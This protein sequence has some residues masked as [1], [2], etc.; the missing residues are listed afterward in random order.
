MHVRVPQ[1]FARAVVARE[2]EAGA[3]FVEGLPGVV[4]GLARRW[5]LRQD[6][7]VLHGQVA[8]VVLVV[9]DDRT[10]A[11]LKVSWRDDETRPE[12]TPLRRWAGVGAVRLLDEDAEAG[13]LLLERLEPQRTLEEVPLDAALAVAAA[14]L[15]ELHVGPVPGVP[16]PRDKAAA[17]AARV[18][19]WAADAGGD[20]RSGRSTRRRRVGLVAR[21]VEQLRSA[22]ATPS[23]DVLLHD[24]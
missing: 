12:A 10:P 4:S 7:P 1:E 2:G 17:T 22:G 21:A 8:V 20:G 19:S 14:L 11:A 15:R 18:E 13:A 24:A 16:L 23:A 6:G 3:S 9:L 5:G